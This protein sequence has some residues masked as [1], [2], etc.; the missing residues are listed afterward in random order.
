MNKTSVTVSI[1]LVAVVIITASVSKQLSVFVAILLGGMV[2]AG[3]TT[4]QAKKQASINGG[5]R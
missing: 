3:Y 1:I 5:A 2:L 4:M